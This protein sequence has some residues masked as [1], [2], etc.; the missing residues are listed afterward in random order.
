MY[1]TTKG[2]SIQS[3]L[4]QHPRYRGR[5][6]LSKPLIDLSVMVGHNSLH[7][8]SMLVQKFQNTFQSLLFHIV[9][10]SNLIALLV[11]QD[12]IYTIIYIL[13]Q[14]EICYCIPEP[15]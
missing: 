15:I 6:V 14:C 5:M 4:L 12:Y 8:Y 7:L 1:A 9:A 3:Y 13:Q 10:S 2:R 11:Y